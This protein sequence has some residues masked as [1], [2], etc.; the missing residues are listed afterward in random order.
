MKWILLVA[1]ILVGL[2]AFVAIIGVLLPKAHV[3]TRAAR[4]R[5]SP[6][7]IWKTITDVDA[8][9]TWR[10]GLQSIERLPDRNGMPAW[11]E[12]S[13][14]GKMPIEVTEWTPPRRMVT[15]IADPSLPFGGTWTY[16]I[17]ATGGATLR[18]TENGEIYNPLFRFMARFVFGYT[19]TMEDY[20]KGLGK[21]FGETVVP[22]S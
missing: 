20:L 10:P 1:G 5:Q 7:S 16:E 21:K 2:V 9:T 19:S 4:F 18:I 14:M 8:M 15:R 11:I 6:E 12:T 3:A 13:S 22:E 17:S